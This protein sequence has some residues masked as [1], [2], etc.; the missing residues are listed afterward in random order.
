MIKKLNE[1]TALK[2]KTLSP[3]EK[4]KKGI[5]GRLYGKVADF[6]NGTRN[7]RKYSE[8]LWQN[9]LESD[10]IKERFANGGIF[11]QLCHPDYEEVDMEKIAV[12]MP[13]PPVKDKDGQL[14][15][16][17]DI[18]DT[19]CGRI[20]YQLAKYGYKLG[21]SSRGT[22]DLIDGPDGEEVDP[23]TYQLNAFDLVEIPAVESARLSFV[24][25]LDNKSLKQSLTESLKKASA[26]DRKLMKE[27][28]DNLGIK[29]NE[30]A[31]EEIAMHDLKER[32]VDYIDQTLGE[33]DW[34]SNLAAAVSSKIP[35]YNM[36][37]CS[38]ELDE[39]NARKIETTKKA[40]CRALADMLFE[41]APRELDST[42]SEE[43][44]QGATKEDK[45][46]FKKAI[47]S[48]FDEIDTTMHEVADSSLGKDSLV[49]KTL[50][51]LLDIIDA[52]SSKINEDVQVE[53]STDNTDVSV[54]DKSDK[55]EEVV[56]DKSDEELVAEFQESLIKIQKLEKDNLS[57][58]EKL[59]VCNAKEIAL[60]EELARYKKATSK[61]SE[62]ALKIKP[63]NNEINQLNEKLSEKDKLMAL[64]KSRVDK[65]IESRKQL[66]KLK[67]EFNSLETSRNSLQENLDNTSKQL[68]ESKKL[69]EKYKKSYK[70][71]KNN[72]VELKATN[73][74]VNKDDVFQR[75]S[76]SYKL[77]DIDSV[78]EELA[79]YK[80]NMSKLPFRITEDTKVG[81]KKSDNEYIKGKE[82][83]AGDD[84]VSDS[85]LQLAEF[86]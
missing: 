7:G 25:S 29:L 82:N 65:L 69:L 11:G 17:V 30:G 84:F 8:K 68:D 27:S 23:D 55:S 28:L 15:A 32:V 77:K 73:Y 33:T 58:Q 70:A 60:K 35:E 79:Q 72:F 10:L 57:L 80:R 64:N 31:A 81:F 59:S 12:V 46:Y 86:K 22:G 42:V 20:A 13:E 1:D 43:L 49:F 62:S 3:E 34:D 14:V 5:L 39:F 74:G 47:D 38:E 61:L 78:C 9:L 56:D 6:T 66:E 2:F 52:S 63:L 75:L 67:D 48:I 4:E 53:V 24:E 16:Y 85:L 36:D 54:S 76:E 41:K 44:E 71:L 50:S 19:P 26:E 40:Y 21:I 83:I 51:K 37:W 45:E 18:L